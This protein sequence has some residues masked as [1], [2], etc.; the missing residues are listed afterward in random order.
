MNNVI[1]VSVTKE[2]WEALEAMLEE[3][4]KVLRETDSFHKDGSEIW[5]NVSAAATFGPTE[6]LIGSLAMIFNIDKHKRTQEEIEIM[7]TD[8]ASRACELEIANHELEAF[9]DAV[10][11][12]LRLPLTIING[13][14]QVIL[15]SFGDNLGEHC[16]EYLQKIYEETIKMNELINTLLSFS[17]LMHSAMHPEMVDLGEMAREIAAGLML[18]QPQRRVNFNVA[19]G[20]VAKAD[21]KLLRVVMENLLGNAWKYTGKKEEALVEFG[22][23][24]FNGKSAYFVRDNGIGFSMNHADKIFAAF[25][26][27]HANKEFEG[28]GIGLCTVRRIIQ[29]HG[30]QVWAEGNV[31][32][33][34]TFYFTLE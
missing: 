24:E 11:H 4:K 14:C 6:E 16:T 19:E 28:I 17:R 25:Q 13:Y 18:A 22:I 3:R 21:A 34:A 31:G 20:V 8:L 32:T 27:L 30:G 2:G 1:P 10:S 9:S 33:G 15:E 12:D 23:T 29:R 5:I 26:R 7:H